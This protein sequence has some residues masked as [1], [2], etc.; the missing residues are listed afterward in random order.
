MSMAA[1]VEDPEDTR[2]TFA[3]TAEIF[4]DVRSEGVGGD[5]FNILSMGMSNDFEVAI[6][7]GANVLRI[8]RALFGEG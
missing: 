2:P 1:M 3:R 6:E 5:Q 7:E 8:G 4:G